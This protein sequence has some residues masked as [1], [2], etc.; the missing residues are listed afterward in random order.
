MTGSDDTRSGEIA[1]GGFFG[2]GMLSVGH[3]V[4]RT[5]GVRDNND[6]DQ[7]VTNLFGQ[8]RLTPAVGLQFEYRDSE[9]EFGDMTKVSRQHRDMGLSV[10][11]SL[12]QCSALSTRRPCF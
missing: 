8:V 7:V 3:S 12:T 5:D 1:A 2:R 11:H 6:A 9:G 10:A 4:D